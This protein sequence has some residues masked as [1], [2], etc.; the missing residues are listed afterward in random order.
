MKTGAL[1]ALDSADESYGKKDTWKFGMT[2]R[3]FYWADGTDEIFVYM[4]KILSKEILDTRFHYY[5]NW[6][7][8]VF[9]SVIFCSALTVLSVQQLGDSGK[10]RFRYDTLRKLGLRPEKNTQCNTETAFDL[11]YD[12]V[13]GFCSDKKAGS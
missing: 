6:P 1:D 4:A 7:M 5:S 12:S 9:D 11:L 10:Y 2:Y 13:C 3:D 8:H